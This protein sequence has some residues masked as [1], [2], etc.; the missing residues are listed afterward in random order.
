[1]PPEPAAV[2][3]AAVTTAAVTTAPVTNAALTTLWSGGYTASMGGSAHGIGLVTWDGA[4]LVWGGTIA[5]T[6]S[7]SWLARKG[8]TLYAADE[9]AGLV[10]AFRIEN[11]SLRFIGSEATS[12]QHPCHIAIID[13]TL[14]VSNYGGGSIDVIPLESDGSLGRPLPPLSAHGSGPRPQQEGPHAHST[15]AAAPGVVLSADLGTDHVHVHRGS[16][17]ALTRDRS[18]QLPPGT[19]PRDLVALGERV[20]VLAEFGS[21]I[22]ELTADA[23]VAD[24]PIVTDPG[25]ADQAAGLI[26]GADGRFLYAGLRGTNRIAVVDAVTLQPVGSVPSAGD[27]PRHLVVA[28]DVLFVCNQRSDSVAAFVIDAATGMPEFAASTAVPTPTFLG[29]TRE[30]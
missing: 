28:D 11:E 25:D 22:F 26:A 27:W 29:D 20:L 1:M 10:S 21:R 9:A 3:T 14:V 13:E 8:S 23:V 24:A 18:I 16:A 2:T 5:E 19:G 17:R 30:R 4:E 6:S 15:L 12:G 7:P